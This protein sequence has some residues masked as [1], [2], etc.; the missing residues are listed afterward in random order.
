MIIYPEEYRES[1][2][3]RTMNKKLTNI[4]EGL[5]PENTILS[6]FRGSISHNTYDLSLVDN[7]DDIDLI[8][9]YIA[10]VDYYIGLD[11]DPLYKRGRQIIKGEFDSVAY[12]LRHFTKL[13]LRFNPNIIPL[14]WLNE[15]HYLSKELPGRILIENRD[16]FSSRHAYKAFTGYANDQLEKVHKKEFKGYMGVKRK[17][18]VEK[19]GYDCKN[20]S[21]AIRLLKMGIEFLETGKLNVYRDKDKSLLLAIKEGKWRLNEL[22]EFAKDLYEDAK[23]ALKKSDLPEEADGTTINEVF[24]EIISD[25][26]YDKYQMPQALNCY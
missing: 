19:F 11:Q 9:V 6:G 23:E 21:H 8:S 4:P 15:R 22:K 17:A 16:C 12:E 5:I 24:M 2:I 7:M 14:L 13:C 20:A 3:M 1:M 25:Y 18:L 10:P 26:I